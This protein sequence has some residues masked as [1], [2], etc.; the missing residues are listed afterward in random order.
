[1]RLF[2]GCATLGT[3]LLLSL[4]VAPAAYAHA[5]YESSDPGN[6]STVSSPP[7]RVTADFT[8]PV[9][10][11][12]RLEVFD[13][14]G[15]QVDSG[16]SFVAADRITVSM[17]ADKQGTYMVRFSVISA[18][19]SHPTNG[20][21]TF[22]STGGAPCPGEEPEGEEPTGGGGGGNDPSGSGD[23]RGNTSGGTASGSDSSTSRAS[24]DRAGGD[25][26]PDG[27]PKGAFG[28]K[29]DTGEARDRTRSKVAG[30]RLENTA[31]AIGP[32]A[33]SA[34]DVNNIWEG[35]E[36]VGYIVALLVAATIGGA[37]GL[38]YAGIMG[39]KE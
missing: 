21:F 13:P 18:V 12:S 25:K 2:R 34:S 15:S 35:I 11:E 27:T 3:T 5:A 8:E 33:I 7:S 23:R 1:M 38:V 37:G 6:Q 39:P 29:K 28:V 24:N 4:S 22:T 30:E 26:S 16:D 9:V 20:E 19:D 32:S 36:P 17:S 31:A 10:D 14:C